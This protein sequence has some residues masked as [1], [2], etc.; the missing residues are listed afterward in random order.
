MEGGGGWGGVSQGVGV[1]VRAWREA[2]CKVQ[3]T[4]PQ[5]PPSLLAPMRA[6]S[7]PQL[8][9]THTHK[10]AAAAAG[11]VARLLAP[12]AGGTRRRGGGDPNNPFDLGWHANLQA[13]CGPEALCWALPLGAAAAGTGL[14]FAT[15]WDAATEGG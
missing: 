1:W 10:A 9:C 8:P 15:A 6:P 14:A 2:D 5:P 4:H 12:A 3:V 7:A 13:V 11:V